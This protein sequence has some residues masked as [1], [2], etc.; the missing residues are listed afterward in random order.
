MQ[1]LRNS[2]ELKLKLLVNGVRIDESAF[3]GLGSTYKE[4][5][6][7]YNDSNWISSYQKR[8]II[9]S[10]LVLPG[11]IVVAPHLRPNSP[12]IIQR[13]SNTM[14]V[15][16]DNTGEVLST[17]NY[18]PRP[19]IW[20]LTLSD[21]S[22]IKQY[23]NV[24]GKN[25]LNLF[26]VANCD[27]WAEG[28]PCSFCSLQP[29]QDFHQEVVVRKQ[30]DKIEEAITLAF[31]NESNFDWMIVT[32]G[33]LVDR[34][35]E[36][37]RYLDV[38]NIIRKHIPQHWN[39]KIK[40]NAALLPSNN[41][42]ELHELYETGIE[43]PSFNLEVWGK[44]NFKRYC[45]GKEAHVS[46]VSL[47]ET[48]IK[49]VKIWGEGH[50]WCNFVGGICPIDDLKE[51]FRYMAD[52]GVVPG[53]NIFHLDPKSHGAKLGLVEP[54]EDYIL[55]MYSYLT[56]IYKEYGYKPFFSHSVLRNSLSN[57]MYNGWI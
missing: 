34:K 12:Y 41:E 24:Y 43:H 32:G 40:G 28:N 49:A 51:G 35:K 25:C 26:I 5:Q 18:L 17:I 30:L 46:F 21:G 8:P 20:N 10:E 55:E 2:T 50:V 48:Y 3:S 33:S 11:E 1:E 56:S 42:K 57:E 9:P 15:I 39:G 53:A 45:P 7:G 36:T 4:Y 44:D 14:Y 37:K 13:D 54:S 22:T 6:Y 27:F 38:L 23:L 31:E 19:K 16:N 47:I 52:M 29:T